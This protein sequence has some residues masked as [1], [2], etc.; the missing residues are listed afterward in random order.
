M[1]KSIYP[2]AKAITLI[3]VVIWL[4]SCKKELGNRNFQVS[5]KTWYRISPIEPIPV[6][7]NGTTYYGVTYFPGGGTGTAT[8]MGNVTIYF[9]QLTYSTAPEAPPAGSIAAPLVDVPDYTVLGGPLPLIQAGDFTELGAINAAFEVPESV[10]GNII[11]SIIYNEKGDAVFFSAITGSGSTFPITQTLIGFDGK[12][13]IVGGRGKFANATGE[14]DYEGN[15]DLTN[16]NNAEYNAE[17]WIR[18]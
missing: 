7:V 6:I 15:F 17:G 11:N 16:A 13:K 5:T 18:Y 12:A 10:S 4:A 14:V 8:H 9:N 1:K 3:G 2:L